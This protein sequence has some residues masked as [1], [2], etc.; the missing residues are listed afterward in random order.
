MPHQ[1][2]LATLN[3]DK[4]LKERLVHC[5]QVLKAHFPF[6]ARIAVTLYDPKTTL[7]KTYVHSSGEDD[8]LSHYQSALDDAPSLKRILEERRPRVVNNLVTFQNG[9]HEHT[10]RIG[11]QG[12]AASYTLPM[13]YQGGFFGFVFFNAYQTDVFTDKA[14]HELDLFAH[15]IALM[16]VDE[17]STLRALTAALGTVA[18]IT[19]QRDP[20]TGSHL[21]RMSRYARLIAQALADSHQLDDTYIEHVFMFA[22]LHDI[23]K[24]AI[25][26]RVLLK[27][28]A[29]EPEELAVMRTH[30]ARGREMIDAIIANFSLHGLQ[31]VEVMRHIAHYHHEAVDGSGYP[32][33]RRGEAIPL[34]ARIVAVADVFDAL[35]SQRP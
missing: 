29:L 14:L 16:V 31:H 30:P 19:H 26:D 17:Q 1:D 6:I 4:P 7:L 11:R 2:I 27:P 25:P 33:G 28:G 22:P 9:R 32:E 15:L 35:T 10:R 34:E 13:F 18:H 21:D 12:Y 20:E 5:H 8:P 23:G 24:V 3:E